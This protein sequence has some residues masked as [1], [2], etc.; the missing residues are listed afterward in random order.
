MFPR[1]SGV[2]D[3]RNGEVVVEAD[4]TAE[5]PTGKILALSAPARRDAEE[6]VDANPGDDAAAGAAPEPGVSTSGRLL[7]PSRAHM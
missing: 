1:G 5:D 4:S 3:V 2:T 6:V 7:F